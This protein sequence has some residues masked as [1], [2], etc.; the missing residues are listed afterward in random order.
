MDIWLIISVGGA[1]LFV[2]FFIGLIIWAERELKK[3]PELIGK[4]DKNDP[5][6]KIGH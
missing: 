6:E 2:L 3:H 5:L 1:I 4:R